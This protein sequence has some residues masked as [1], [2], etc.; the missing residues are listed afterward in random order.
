[1]HT[2]GAHQWLHLQDLIKPVFH[3]HGPRPFDGLWLHLEDSRS[4]VFSPLREDRNNGQLEDALLALPHLR[5][6]R[7]ALQPPETR[8]GCLDRNTYVRQQRTSHIPSGFAVVRVVIH[9][10]GHQGKQTHSELDV[11]T[12]SPSMFYLQTDQ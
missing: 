11:L 4:L 6:R 8:R 9:S 2:S 1:M 7:D 5:W 10:R 12:S 3:R